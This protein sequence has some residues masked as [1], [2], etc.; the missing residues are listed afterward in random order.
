LD[1]GV[2][3][4]VLGEGFAIHAWHFVVDKCDIVGLVGLGGLGEGGE[5]GWAVDGFLEVGGDW[6]EGGGEEEA[7]GI[8]VID[9]EDTEWVGSVLWGLGLVFWVW[10]LFK[11]GGEPEGGAF[12]VL[13]FDTDGSSHHF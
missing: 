1:L 13:A 7:I 2:G 12:A 4:D 6:A 9:D 3:F 11:C 8:E 10:V 5:G